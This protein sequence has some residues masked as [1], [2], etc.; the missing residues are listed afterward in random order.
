MG[1]RFAG[2]R[3]RL[4]AA[5]ILNC[6]FAGA[7]WAQDSQPSGANNGMV[8]AGAQ[9]VADSTDIGC[10]PAGLFASSAAVAQT[11]AS[12]NSPPTTPSKKK[13]VAAPN[14]QA[15]A[16]EAAG[17]IIVTGQRRALES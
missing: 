11:T 6:G 14:S 13:P 10:A 12:A 2:Y 9:Q 3:S 1:R 15:S 5:T 16:S 8:P 17:A 7:A 4:I